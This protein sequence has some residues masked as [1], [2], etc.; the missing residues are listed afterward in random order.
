MTT[1]ADMDDV[2]AE[3]RT[4]A[5][6]RGIRSVAGRVESLGVPHKPVTLPDGWQGIYA[7]RWQGQWLK[8]GKAGPNTAARWLSQ[9]YGAG[10]AMSTLAFSLLRYGHLATR[11]HPSLPGLRTL[12]QRVG[13]QDIGDWIKENTERVNVLVDAAAGRDGLA[14]LEGIAH[15]RLTPIF[16]GRWPFGG[17]AA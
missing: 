8:I 13:P 17:P 9:H 6:A 1:V 15:R 12:L 4:W 7:F 11:E 5:Q 16:E 3:W 2:L 14:S 10:R